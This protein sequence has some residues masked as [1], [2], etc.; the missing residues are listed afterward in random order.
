MDTAV[1][2]SPLP[3]N[4]RRMHA[5]APCSHRMTLRAD[6]ARHRAGTRSLTG[7]SSPSPAAA[8]STRSTPPARSR[9]AATASSRRRPSPETP[10]SAP[11][12]CSHPSYA[13][14][15]SPAPT[16]QTSPPSPSSPP[17][18]GRSTPV[19]T[20]SHTHPPTPPPTP[21]YP[22]NTHACHTPVV[23]RRPQRH[24]WH[25]LFAAHIRLTTVLT[26]AVRRC[27][28]HWWPH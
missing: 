27:A 6:R 11:S 19:R 14:S 23:P 18:C 5:G 25:A 8:A 2:S 1:Y 24:P 13:A 16:P 15:A 9:G 22:C 20:C 12:A 21:P 17:R 4:K 7:S 28:L 10:P 3:Y 26:A